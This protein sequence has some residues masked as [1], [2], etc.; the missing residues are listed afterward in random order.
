MYPNDVMLIIFGV[1][2]GISIIFFGIKKYKNIVKKPLLIFPII[3][4]VTFIYLFSFYMPSKI[5][6]VRVEE[7]RIST[8]LRI[9]EETFILELAKLL[10][11]DKVRVI[12]EK[13]NRIE[14]LANGEI[15]L[16]ITNG[17]GEREEIQAISKDGNYI[18]QRK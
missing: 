3:F 16:V 6:D 4:G 17:E 11:V 15:Y 1:V 8:N 7:E 13:P 2:V 10:E 14:V 12:K 18:Y 5:S 9:K